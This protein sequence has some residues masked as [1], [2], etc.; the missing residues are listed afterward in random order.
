MSVIGGSIYFLGYVKK[1]N[2]HVKKVRI[3]DDRMFC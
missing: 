3:T 1:A 2:R